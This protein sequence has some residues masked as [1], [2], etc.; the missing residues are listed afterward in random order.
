MRLDTQYRR[1]G[2]GQKEAAYY[3]AQGVPAAGEPAIQQVLDGCV[4]GWPSLR[5]RGG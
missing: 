2:A 5:A 4:G 3:L 1:V